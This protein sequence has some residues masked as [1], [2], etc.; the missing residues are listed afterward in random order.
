MEIDPA[1]VNNFRFFPELRVTSLTYIH[2]YIHLYLTMQVRRIGKTE[3]LNCP[4]DL[5]Q[6]DIHCFMDTP[7]NEN[8]N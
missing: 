5:G 6:R 2:T 7:S 8:L 4:V 1:L 3:V